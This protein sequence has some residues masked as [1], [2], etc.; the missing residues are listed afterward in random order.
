MVKLT[1]TEKTLL[2][3]KRKLNK[4]EYDCWEFDPKLKDA[5]NK[6]KLL[7][8]KVNHER[9]V[10]QLA[11]ATSKTFIDNSK[12]TTKKT[13]KNIGNNNNKKEFTALKK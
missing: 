9:K 7:E 1:P 13:Y 4:L 10:E 11:A 5:Q 3:E 12:N 2:K 6:V 8:E